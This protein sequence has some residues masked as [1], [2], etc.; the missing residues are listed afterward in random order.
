[1]EST[2][3]TSADGGATENE[4]LDTR[5]VEKEQDVAKGSVEVANANT[6]SPTLCSGNSETG[7][8]TVGRTENEALETGTPEKEPN[9]MEENTE[10]Q[11]ANTTSPTLRSGNLETGDSNIGR[12]ENEALEVGAPEKGPDRMEKN[13]ETQNANTTSPTLRSGNSETGAS[14]VGR[15]E[16]EALETGAPEKEPD[17]MEENMEAQTK[18][19]SK[20]QYQDDVN[21]DKHQK[22]DDAESDDDV[23]PLDILE[24]KVPMEVIDLTDDNE[25]DS[26][27]SLDIPEG[28]SDD[29]DLKPPSIPP[30]PYKLFHKDVY[31][32]VQNENEELRYEVCRKIIKNMWKVL[33]KEEQ[34]LYM[35]QYDV[36]VHEYNKELERYNDEVRRRKRHARKVPITSPSMAMTAMR[37]LVLNS[38]VTTPVVGQLPHH[39]AYAVPDSMQM[40]PEGGVMG[41]IR[42]DYPYMNADWGKVARHGVSN[43]ESVPTVPQ[44]SQESRPSRHGKNTRKKPLTP[45]FRYNKEVYRDIKLKHPDMEF[46]AMGKLIGKMWRELPAEVVEVYRKEYV[47]EKRAYDRE[48]ALIKL[49]DQ[50]RELS[51]QAREVTH[52][53]LND[54]SH[55][56]S[57][58]QQIAKNNWMQYYANEKGPILSGSIPCIGVQGSGSQ[59]GQMASLA[60]FQPFQPAALVSSQEVEILSSGAPVHQTQSYRTVQVSAPAHLTSQISDRVQ[61]NSHSFQSSLSDVSVA[62]N[63]KDDVIE[64]ERRGTRVI[65]FGDTTEDSAMAQ[66]QKLFTVIGNVEPSP[67]LMFRGTE[68]FKCQFCGLIMHNQELY[69]THTRQHSEEH[70]NT[71]MG[72]SRHFSNQTILQQHKAVCNASTVSNQ[73]ES[74]VSNQ[75]ESTVSNQDESM[76]LNEQE[77]APSEEGKER[78]QFIYMHPT[79]LHNS[80]ES[81]YVC[82]YCLKVVKVND[83]ETH[84][85]GC[86]IVVDMNTKNAGDILSAHIDSAEAVDSSEVDGNDAVNDDDDDDV[87]NDDDDG[88]EI[89][90]WEIAP[91]T[92]NTLFPVKYISDKDNF[93]LMHKVQSTEE[94][95]SQDSNNDVEISPLG[96]PSSEIIP[97][98]N[99]GIPQQQ[100]FSNKT[101]LVM[102]SNIISQVMESSVSMSQQMNLTGGMPV[103]TQPLNMTGRMQ[104]ATQPLNMSGRMQG[105]TQLLN[106]TG[107]MQGTTQPL[108][109]TG[110]MPVTTQPL[111]MTGGMQVATQPLNLTEG[112]QKQLSIKC[113]HCHT[114]KYSD[115]GAVLTQH[116]SNCPGAKCPH[117]LSIFK[118]KRSSTLKIHLTTC[119]G[120]DPSTA[121]KP[122]SINECRLCDTCFA[123]EHMLEEH[124]KMHS[125]DELMNSGPKEKPEENT[126]KMMVEICPYCKLRMFFINRIN[127][128]RHLDICDYKPEKKPKENSKM[129]HEVCRYCNKKIF[130]I[131]RSTFMKHLDNCMCA[132]PTYCQY[133]KM[134]YD[135]KSVNE[136]KLHMATCAAD[137]PGVKSKADGMRRKQEC[138]HCGT[139]FRDRGDFEWHVQSLSIEELTERK[140]TCKYCRKTISYVDRNDFIKHSFNCSKFFVHCPYCYKKY[141]CRTTFDVKYHLATCTGTGEKPAQMPNIATLYR[142][143][144]TSLD[145]GRDCQF[146]HK[147][148]PDRVEFASHIASHTVEELY[149][150][151]DRKPDYKPDS[152][153]LNQS[154]KSGA[155]NPKDS[156]MFL[157]FP[158]FSGKDFTLHCPYCKYKYIFSL[159]YKLKMHLAT[160]AGVEKPGIKPKGKIHRLVCLHCSI[161]FKKQQDFESHI[162]SHFVEELMERGEQN[163]EEQNQGEQLAWTINDPTQQ[164]QKRG[165]QMAWTVIDPTPQSPS[166][167]SGPGSSDGIANNLMMSSG[168]S[169]IKKMGINQ[170]RKLECPHCDLTMYF[171]RELGLKMH[172]ATCIDSTTRSKMYSLE[173]EKTRNVCEYCN[174]NLKSRDSLERHVAR[175]DFKSLMRLFKCEECGQK[176]RF[177][178][179]FVSHKRVHARQKETQVRN[180]SETNSGVANL[181]IAAVKGGIAA[182]G[183]HLPNEGPVLSELSMFCPHCDDSIKYQ[184]DLQ[185]KL[186]LATCNAMNDDRRKKLYFYSNLSICEICDEIFNTKDVLASHVEMHT[187]NDLLTCKICMSC[188]QRFRHEDD[189]LK[190][191]TSEHGF[192]GLTGSDAVVSNM[193]SSKNLP[194]KAH[195]VFCSHC[196]MEVYYDHESELRMH[197]ATCINKNPELLK[198]RATSKD[199]RSTYVCQ[200]CLAN[201]VISKYNLYQEMQNHVERNHS[202]SSLLLVK[203]CKLCNSNFRT[204]SEL[205][206]HTNKWGGRC[207]NAMKEIMKSMTKE[208]MVVDK[209][210]TAGTP[211]TKSAAQERSMKCPHCN[212]NIRYR[213]I[214]DLQYHLATCVP[215]VQ[216]K[217]N[218]VCQ[219]CADH[220]AE[221]LDMWGHAQSHLFN[222]LMTPRGIPI[223]MA[224]R[225]EHWG[226]LKLSSIKKVRSISLDLDDSEDNDEE[227]RSSTSPMS[228]RSPGSKNCKYCNAALLSMTRNTDNP[229]ECRF[230]HVTVMSSVEL[231]KH[232]R[233]HMTSHICVKCPVCH[234]RHATQK[235]LNQHILCHIKSYT[236]DGGEL[237]CHAC[238]FR[239]SL[240]EAETFVFHVISHQMEGRQWAIQDPYANSGGTQMATQSVEARHEMGVDDLSGI[241]IKTEKMDSDEGHE[242]GKQKEIHEAATVARQMESNKAVKSQASTSEEEKSSERTEDHMSKVTESSGS[243]ITESFQ[244]TESSSTT[245][246]VGISDDRM[247]ETNT[248]KVH[249]L[250]DSRIV[251]TSS[252]STIA[253]ISNRVL[254]ESSNSKIL[255][256]SGNKNTETSSNRSIAE[257]CNE[258]ISESTNSKIPDSTNSK[259]PESTNSK[260]PESLDSNIPES[261]DKKLTE[262]SGSKI[263]ELSNCKTSESSTN[264]T[265]ESSG[266]K[267]HQE[268]SGE[269]SGKS[270]GKVVDTP[271]INLIA[272]SNVSN[273]PSPSV[274][275]LC[276]SSAPKPTACGDSNVGA[277][278]VKCIPDACKRDRS[279]QGPA[280][281][282]EGTDDEI[283]M[284][285]DEDVSDATDLEEH[286]YSKSPRYKSMESNE[287]DDPSERQQDMDAVEST[288]EKRIDVVVKES[289]SACEVD[290]DVTES[291]S[292]KEVDMDMME[293]TSVMDV[294]E[295]NSAKD[296]DVQSEDKGAQTKNGI[297]FFLK[298]TKMEGLTQDHSYA[299]GIS[300]VSYRLLKDQKDADNIKGGI[301][302]SKDKGNN[303]IPK[304]GVTGGSEKESLN[305]EAK[306]MRDESKADSGSTWVADIGISAGLRDQKEQTEKENNDGSHAN[307]GSTPIAEVG[308]TAEQKESKNGSQA[309][310]GSTLIAET[311]RTAEQEELAEKSNEIMDRNAKESVN[312]SE[313]DRVG[314]IESDSSAEL[315]AHKEEDEK[316]GINGSKMELGIIAASRVQKD[317]EEEK[318]S[319]NK[320]ETENVI[321]KEKND[322]NETNRRSAQTAAVDASALVGS[323][324]R[325]SARTAEVD[326]SALVR[327]GHRGSARTA[328][329][330]SSALVRSGH[331]GS[332]PTAAVDSSDE[333]GSGR[334]CDDIGEVDSENAPGIGSVLSDVVKIKEEPVSSD[335]DD[336]DGGV[337]KDNSE[338]G[339]FGKESNCTVDGIDGGSKKPVD[340]SEDAASNS[341]H[342]A[343]QSC[344]E[345]VRYQQL[346]AVPTT[347]ISQPVVSQAQPHPLAT[348]FHGS[349][350]SVVLNDAGQAIG[351]HSQPLVGVSATT[352]N[353]S[354]AIVILPL[355]TTTVNQSKPVPI[356]LQPTTTVN[357][358]KPVP[359]QPRPA[360]TVNSSQPVLI[361]PRPQNMVTVH[362]AKPVCL[363]CT[364]RHD[365]NEDCQ[366][367]QQPVCPF[368]NKRHGVNQRC[369]TMV[370]YLSQYDSTN[371]GKS[372]VGPVIR[373]S[374]LPGLEPSSTLIYPQTDSS[375]STE[376]IK[377]LTKRIPCTNSIQSTTEGPPSM[378]SSSTNLIESQTNYLLSALTSSAPSLSSVPSTSSAPSTP[379]DKSP[380]TNIEIVEN[381]DAVNEARSNAIG[382]NHYRVVQQSLEEQLKNITP[383]VDYSIAEGSKWD[384][385]IVY[386]DPESDKELGDIR[387]P[388]CYENHSRPLVCLQTMVYLATFGKYEPMKVGDGQRARFMC[389]IC[390]DDF[391]WDYN[392]RAHTF[393]RHVK[394][395]NNSDVSISVKPGPVPVKVSEDKYGCPRCRSTFNSHQGC[396]SHLKVCDG[397]DD[398][399]KKSSMTPYKSDKPRYRCPFCPEVHTR[400]YNCRYH[401]QKQHTRCQK[402]QEPNEPV[403]LAHQ[404]YLCPFCSEEFPRE[405]TCKKHIGRKHLTEEQLVCDTCNKSYNRQ[406]EHW[407]LALPI[408]EKTGHYRCPYCP[409]KVFTRCYN[410]SAHI[411]E[412]HSGPDGNHVLH[413]Y[414]DVLH[415]S[416]GRRVAPPIPPVDPAVM[417]KLIK[418]DETPWQQAVMKGKQ[419]AAKWQETAVTRCKICGVTYKGKNHK[420]LQSKCPH[421]MKF[422]SLRS[423]LMKHILADHKLNWTDGDEEKGEQEAGNPKREMQEL[424]A[425]ADYYGRCDVEEKTDN[426]EKSSVMETSA[427]V[428]EIEEISQEE[429]GP[430]VMSDDNDDVQRLPVIE[431]VYSQ[432]E[433]DDD[434]PSLMSVDIDDGQRLPVIERVY[435]QSDTGSKDDSS[436]RDESMGDDEEQDDDILL[437]SQEEKEETLH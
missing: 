408:R 170:Q 196:D 198:E 34:Q 240:I 375:S 302:G 62:Q 12:T 243:T 38:T 353:Q 20:D 381:L 23:I 73:D 60:S 76:E 433:N 247:D 336:D 105:T 74:T 140:D 235:R 312:L 293:S 362:D 31:Q 282:D 225:H 387:C 413:S 267:I 48:T 129:L 263:A 220:Y 396:R 179:G 264:K 145:Q 236:Q 160:C 127:F 384:P 13:T 167:K 9:R 64:E 116:I 171:D 202:M 118:F 370:K 323:G 181:Q 350:N 153:S 5:S 219:V 90:R 97:A 356:Q 211:Q 184:T 310:I 328:E 135:F 18:G 258:M 300:V 199:N 324:H 366:K 289:T 314:T 357:Q 191:R 342:V 59:G 397:T 337:L 355:P 305:Q 345:T 162:E 26:S 70:A 277:D 405:T 14:T 138:L 389:P 374:R 346:V 379:S 176:F 1:M 100:E 311:G 392:C 428:M 297:T 108:N 151:G 180:R 46:G 223:T 224:N 119:Q 19:T 156:E 373:P 218:E 426:D 251:E 242:G 78:K 11:N 338:D 164:E 139:C 394:N 339:E 102:A 304:F 409:R 319:Q 4:A 125:V 299:K 237:I 86:G 279:S 429:N 411:R 270:S 169:I 52:Q 182:F 347:T 200:V 81:G 133:C 157:S 363:F 403:K 152:T 16:N 316:E 168:V 203:T 207:N 229:H 134:E 368:C 322:G 172:L 144:D 141:M 331:R 360:T 321:G 400:P 96:E 150:R 260:I 228:P 10:A 95:L 155:A 89:S 364:Y 284:E 107:R 306:E 402:P 142:M 194:K 37:D 276:E 351:N 8:S 101:S 238:D 423:D 287:S 318:E 25:M 417:Q 329:V 212:D 178:K 436:Y 43:F 383:T 421:C 291:T 112:M 369:D 51:K 407:C 120:S 292:A 22:T 273:K 217:P 435:S 286:S 262:S 252:D 83:L 85:K 54:A 206:K 104:V 385:S 21:V 210:V 425:A 348:V 94:D 415:G 358:S 215:V 261:S 30:S 427:E 382:N 79:Q 343:E 327:S 68:S 121:T 371:H 278:A 110:R 80:T 281:A 388:F 163:Q 106:M 208:S 315:R 234:G 186:H 33:P 285:I 149:K 431:R 124:V 166:D 404:R 283:A 380:A 63:Q 185:L 35:K 230:C 47:K 354:Q 341:R 367:V 56:Q 7:A 244:S 209:G 2:V 158:Y 301:D 58:V 326:S 313:V 352:V 201:Q 265:P 24:T 232:E 147:T 132:K 288:S 197:L 29:S 334:Q 377:N 87:K 28:F 213:L 361:Q 173:V 189:L 245:M 130:F 308:R 255:E 226:R 295:S 239:E 275:T 309:N 66:L 365:I 57:S 192:H 241:K 253:T 294:K 174:L 188:N 214:E 67:D 398:G 137:K 372:T 422:F 248:S 40:E 49:K 177:E 290:M 128:M 98:T 50:E 71:C 430:S 17:H 250:S 27:T 123:T 84:Q 332:P 93:A 416:Q 55:N 216:D 325:G 254:P 419:N 44:T 65:N 386:D 391:P 296:K 72:C 406:E 393:S 193:V 344:D 274:T 61:S 412:K 231:R 256:P 190:H 187:M 143:P 205:A 115:N 53:R 113:I 109:M 420:C 335:D 222:D 410:C 88:D 195:H 39:V 271:V 126:R 257:A 378:T 159:L 249:E 418:F 424:M 333:V 340:K 317:N 75:D 69:Q 227:E 114:T 45:Y 36:T 399:R 330:D 414:Q 77:T 303:Q 175:H 6:T 32:S 437:E 434:V 103:A 91:G 82:I 15:T 390:Y 117:C 432:S 42:K 41:R 146:C 183:H 320:K 401:V 395:L 269:S 268:S 131:D 246:K 280:S 204:K 259:I 148:I 111:N 221:K 349:S 122:G 161:T 376:F 3:K 99:D 307:I 154:E 136:V 272:D 359:I 233:D 165:E 92:S 266:S 298:K